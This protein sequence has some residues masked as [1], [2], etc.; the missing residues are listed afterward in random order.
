M[1]DEHPTIEF[2]SARLRGL[3]ARMEAQKI[4]FGPVVFQGSVR[5]ICG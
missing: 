2:P 5:E 1:I 4:A 3:Q